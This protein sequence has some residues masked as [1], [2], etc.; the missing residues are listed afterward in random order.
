MQQRNL[1]FLAGDLGIQHPL[2]IDLQNMRHGA[3]LG[4]HHDRIPHFDFGHQVGIELVF[5]DQFFRP[6]I[7]FNQHDAF[8]SPAIGA[9]AGFATHP[10]RVVH[11]LVLM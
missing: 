5:P 11:R 3:A 9:V 4:V 6:R 1:V 8:R 7:D 2:V 10:D